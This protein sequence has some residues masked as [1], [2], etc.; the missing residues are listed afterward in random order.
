MSAYKFTSYYFKAY[1]GIMSVNVLR[2]IGLCECR[3]FVFPNL[4]PDI[5]IATV[6]DILIQISNMNTSRPSILVPKHWKCVCFISEFINNIYSGYNLALIYYQY[7]LVSTTK[8]NSPALEN[9]SFLVC[10]FSQ[11][12]S[13][14][15]SFNKRMNSVTIIGPYLWQASTTIVIWY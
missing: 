8:T 7:S 3:I 9:F 15:S 12:F 2:T 4:E 5:W 10:K 11:L 14:P 1:I 6:T 13:M